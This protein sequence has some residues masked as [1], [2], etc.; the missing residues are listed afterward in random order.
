MKDDNKKNNNG[1]DKKIYQEV[2]PY[3]NLGLQLALTIGICVIVGIYIDKKFTSEPIFT[4]IF[5]FLGIGVGFYNFFRTI[6]NNN[7]NK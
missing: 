4:I 6:N 5:I 3:L 7:N 2:A 1:N